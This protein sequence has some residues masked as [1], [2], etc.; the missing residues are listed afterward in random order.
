MTDN[1]EEVRLN[2]VNICIEY[3]I[4][5]I[6]QCNESNRLALSLFAFETA[7]LCLSDNLDPWFDTSK[8]IGS[9]NCDRSC[10]APILVRDLTLFKRPQ[11]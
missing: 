11:H 2:P 5:P 7:E 1:T 9:K 6:L 4:N 8:L 10:T 3:T